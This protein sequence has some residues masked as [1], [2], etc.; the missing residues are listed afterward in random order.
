MAKNKLEK[1]A[2]LNDE[3]KAIKQRQSKLR[4]EHNKKERKERNHRLCQRGGLVEKLLPGLITLTDEQFEVFVE[5]TLLTP[6]TKRILAELV[7]P[8]LADPKGIAD[9]TQGSGNTPEMLPE[10]AVHPLTTPATKS[11]ATVR[12]TPANASGEAVSAERR[13]S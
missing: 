4:Q 3:I 5:K 6:H 10:K 11:P 7:P 9:E 8:A 12:N 13:A 1:I 2:E